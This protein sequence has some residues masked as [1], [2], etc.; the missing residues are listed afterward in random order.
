MDGVHMTAVTMKMHLSFV[1]VSNELVSRHIV[2]ITRVL[3]EKLRLIN[4][5]W[6]H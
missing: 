1:Q 3:D 2:L 6:N 4:A 5:L